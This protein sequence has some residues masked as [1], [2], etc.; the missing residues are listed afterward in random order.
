MIFAALLAAF[1]VCGGAAPAR[2]EVPVASTPLQDS[3]TTR[4]AQELAP[5]AAITDGPAV[6][7]PADSQF[8]DILC[9][10]DA[11]EK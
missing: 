5:P 1:T 9:R 8:Q 6:E 10:L 2:A 3:F 11:L 4:D 7:W